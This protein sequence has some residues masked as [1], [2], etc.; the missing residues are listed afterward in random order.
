[1]ENAILVITPAVIR[2]VMVKLALLMETVQQEPVMEE[3][4]LLARLQ[5]QVN[6]VIKFHVQKTMIA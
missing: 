4:V 2:N 5:L 6:Y 3:N 1:M